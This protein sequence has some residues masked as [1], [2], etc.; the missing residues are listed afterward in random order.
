MKKS[1]SLLLGFALLLGAFCG[2][3][4]SDTSGSNTS[5]TG[6]NEISETGTESATGGIGGLVGDVSNFSVTAAYDYGMHVEDT[7]YML[8]NGIERFFD[9]PEE[10]D[11]VVA[12]DTFHIVHTGEIHIQE[13]Y[14]ASATLSGEIVQVEVRKAQVL[15]LTYYAPYDGAEEYFEVWHDNGV[16]EKIT[17]KSRPDYYIRDLNDGLFS[18]L[19]D[20]NYSTTLYGTYNGVNGCDSDGYTLLG[21]Y[22]WHPR[23]KGREVHPQTKAAIEELNE[24]SD[25]TFDLLAKKEACDFTDYE[26]TPG[27]G[28]E[29]YEKDGVSYGFSTY[30]DYASG[31]YCI[32]SIFSQGGNTV[33]G[34]KGDE[35]AENVAEALLSYGYTLTAREETHVSGSKYGVAITFTKTDGVWSVQIG[36]RSTNDTGIMY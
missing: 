8:Y 34:V 35:A 30:P 14:P 26:Y 13:S 12:G 17:V 24:K 6:K 22:R 36:L 9:I 11:T 31:A 4:G 33:F 15:R 16:R 28:C 1:I 25:F 18:P 10:L 2:C 20:V 19:S 27:F 7:A 5:G 32:T 23:F 3:G 21:L 29:S